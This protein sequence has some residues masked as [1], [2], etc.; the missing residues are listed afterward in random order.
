VLPTVAIIVPIRGRPQ[1]IAPLLDSIRAATMEPHRVVFVPDADDAASIAALD[2][3][4]AEFVVNDRG[5]NPSYAAKINVGVSATASTNEPW[6]FTAADDLYFH[7]GWLEFALRSAEPHHRVIG[8]NDLCNPAT[9]RGDLSTHS[10]VSREYV[11]RVGAVVDKP[12]GV[13]Y[14]EGYGHAYCDQELVS[15]AK[16]RGV[17]VHAFDSLVEHLHPANRRRPAPDDDTYR[18]GAS[19]TAESRQV[20]DRRRHLWATR[21]TEPRPPTIFVQVAAYREPE[22]A[23]TIASCLDE[24][25]HPGRLRF[26][27]CL[28]HDASIP[29]AGPECLD[30]LRE[31]AE[32]RLVRLR[33]HRTRGG[34]WARFVAQGLYDGEDYTLQID[35]HSRMRSGWDDALVTLLRALPDR[36]PLVTGS[37]ALYRLVYGEVELLEPQWEPVG[38]TRIAEWSRDGWIH[39]T[40]EPPPADAMLTARRTRVLSGGFVFTLG[41]WNVEVRQDPEHLYTGEELALT[42]RSFTSGYDLWNPPRRMLWHRTHP[43]PN[44]KY[45]HDDPDGWSARRHERAC[46][47]LRVLL[48]GDPERILDP[49]SL[50]SDRPLED[51]WE[52]AGLRWPEREITRAASDGYPAPGP[53]VGR[54]HGS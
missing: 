39:H 31:R 43:A 4:G 10:M 17:Y 29:G 15:T 2:A 6:V 21:P 37:P 20:I 54:T 41:A 23:A 8:T 28:Q 24:A 11:D 47:R 27:V 5:A 49:F 14:H 44:P 42:L 13:L 53:T 30:A 3:A 33:H 18:I 12:P 45:V 16:H 7:P 19:K 51:Y 25:L 50:G 26:G 46:R 9:E 52:F 32:V 48:N 36:K 22:L 35:A 1:R 38:V 34:C 40:T